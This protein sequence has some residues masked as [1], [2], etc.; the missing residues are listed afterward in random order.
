[1]RVKGLLLLVA[2]VVFV[3]GFLA[4]VVAVEKVRDG[5]RE[6][7]LRGLRETVRA[8]ALLVDREVQRS[9]GAM[10]A[11]AQ[12]E[13]L[14]T[15]NL[16]G[17]HEQALA[18]NQPYVWTLLFDET[19]TQLINTAV[20][21]GTPPP[22]PSAAERVA[23]VLATNRLL[24]SDVMRGPVSGKLLTTLYF[25]T[26]E[27]N[28]KR[29]VVAQAF[30][31]EHWKTS[32]LQLKNG[33][34]LTVGVIDRN[35]LFVSR[36]VNAD[37]L[38][39]KP[40]RPELVAAAASASEGLIR[41]P[42]LEGLDSYDA[43]THSELTG[44]TVAVAVPVKTIEASATQAV[45]WLAAAGALA[46][47]AGLTA[48]VLLG[49]LFIRVVDDTARAARQIGDGSAPVLPRSS[50][51]EV[52][53]LYEALARA[54]E[55]IVVERRSREAAEAERGQL[56][57]RETALREEAQRQ[58][59]AKDQFLALLG[60][61]LRN[62]LAAISGA[63]A[64]LSHPRTNPDAKENF[65][66]IIQRQNRHLR[67]IVD[68]LLDVSRLASGR[69]VLDK[70]ALN[71][72]DCVRSCVDALRASERAAKHAITVQADDV[73]VDG[74][75]VRLEQIVNNLVSNSLK[76]SPPG[77]EIRVEVRDAGDEA[78]IRVV[79]AG[80]GISAELMPHIFKLFVQGPALTGSM[81]SG[82]G[83][84]L[85][86]V[87]QLVELHGGRVHAESQGGGTGATFIVTLPKMARPEVRA[88][89]PRLTEHVGRR[90]LLVEDDADAMAATSELL[91]LM[92]HRVVQA[93]NREEVLRMLATEQIDIIV[94]DI[95]MPGQDGYEIAK[96]LRR[97]PATRSMPMIALTGF[98]QEVDRSRALVA[99]F[100]EHLV[101]P[102]D[103][104]RLARVID[105]LSPR[106]ELVGARS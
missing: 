94:M 70:S 54:G 88:D 11:L 57:E 4:A 33:S 21:F 62:P 81:S 39:G 38:L 58:N 24:V 12:S 2:A 85:A 17:F 51:E 67:H 52:N 78:V 30:S 16:K 93:K 47:A 40:A 96:E 103:P 90:V 104:D 79:D 19:G 98:G 43:F 53:A 49:R 73:W 31:I 22:S 101:K 82:L 6:A 80:V 71:L 14:L 66:A 59:A 29:Y 48:A 86:L 34:S 15:G 56:L 44:W 74:D 13:H 60:H 77:T 50:L 36:N 45:L 92:N 76:C 102:V 55:Q 3:P 69:I 9:V 68:D 91:R 25:P 72:A 28:G 27:W 42:T 95:G 75:S 87:K 64:V 65:L 46:L 61:E 106:G 8:S 5:E 105:T 7:S 89:A 99:G 84:G 32:A 100:N 41:H 83:I 18:I 23:Q 20:P 63:T 97:L 26:K 35:G 10:T 37:A 1:M